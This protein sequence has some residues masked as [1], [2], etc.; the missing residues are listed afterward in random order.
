MAGISRELVLKDK[1]SS[2]FDKFI[3]KTKDA[4]S[5]VAKV[6]ESM[7][8]IGEVIDSAT[9]RT[10]SWTDAVGHM[11]KEALQATYTFEE[12]VQQGLLVE[13]AMQAV[14][15]KTEEVAEKVEEP[16]D[17]MEDWLDE[18]NELQHFF[19]GP[20]DQMEQMIKV[21]GDWLTAFGTDSEQGKAALQGLAYEVQ[22]YGDN[23]IKAGQ[24]SDESIKR[25]AGSIEKLKMLSDQGLIKIPRSTLSDMNKIA[26]KAQELSNHAKNANKGF[27]GLGVTLKGLLTRLL[28]IGAVLRTFRN[29]ME[30]VPEE[31]MRPFNELKSFFSDTLG[32]L[33]SSF[34]KGA[35]SGFEALRN[36]F[37]SSGL[38]ASLLGLQAIFEVVGQTVGYFL[39]V[40]A[41]LAEV[42]GNILAPILNLTWI[43]LSGIFEVIQTVIEGI[44]NMA[45]TISGVLSP[46]LQD[47]GVTF[48]SVMGVIEDVF[49]VLYY[50]IYN[51]FADIYNVIASFAEFFANVFNDPIKAIVLLFVDLFNVILDIVQSAA[52]LIDALLGSDIEGAVAG[53]QEKVNTWVQEHVGDNSVQIDRMEKISFDDARSMFKGHGVNGQVELMQRQNAAITAAAGAAGS[54]AKAADKT[55]AA[56]KDIA[57]D[58]K[59][60][61]DAITDEELKMLIDVATQKFVSNV[62]LTSQTP[63]I[64]INGGNIGSKADQRR[65]ANTIRDMLIE[66]AASG[67]TSTDY[68]YAGA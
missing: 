54:A 24:K 29:A 41:S 4:E 60:I 33:M 46:T 67:S 9:G 6:E 36:A 61:K 42:L 3:K 43:L 2:V 62:N 68:V 26:K 17:A 25:M 57:A 1:F 53:F 45:A 20:L 59:E 56:T 66:Q 8:K 12:L 30:R 63:V 35:S 55:A 11:N 51:V 50:V 40:V 10:Y 21:T 37:E 49:A 5:S 34:F 44:G 16:K 19:D 15:D 64:T 48:E 47:M 58:T 18:V 13:E 7:Q 14:A 39:S 28:G 38:Q 27:L 65:L 31:I 23:W 22:I 52:H 32:R